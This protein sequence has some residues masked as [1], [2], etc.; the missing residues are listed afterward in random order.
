MTVGFVGLGRMGRPM[1]K[2]LIEAGFAVVAYDSDPTAVA[3]IPAARAAASLAEVAR[4]SEVVI[5]ML[6]DGET[7]RRVTVGEGDHLL[8][9]LTPGSVLVDMSSSA[10]DGTRTLGATLARRGVT[11]LDAPVSGGV[12]RAVTGE[13]SILV[14]GDRAAFDRCR[15]LFDAMGASVFHTGPLGSGH[16]VKALNNLL[17]AAGFLA[18]SEALLIGRRYGL[19]PDVMLDV[20]NASTGRNNS[21]EMKFRQHVLSATFDSNF[22]LDLMVKDLRIALGVS[23]TAGAATP[24]SRLCLELW[25]AGRAK[26]PEGADHTELARWVWRE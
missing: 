24:L 14:G 5:T 8:A 26:L 4:A 22:S 9:G 19:D 23:E 11:M 20:F 1:V 2:N 10:P 13:L 15:P 12:R 16:A 18:A 25:E 6:P 17:S 3:D 7:V 21:T